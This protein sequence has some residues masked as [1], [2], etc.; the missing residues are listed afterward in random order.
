[1]KY[2][3]MAICQNCKKKNTKEVERDSELDMK[4]YLEIK[5]SGY[6]TKCEFCEYI[7]IQ[8]PI[9][10]KLADNSIGLI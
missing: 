6:A 5:N 3:V 9:A 7:T 1:M 10:F 8:K 4:L 2:E